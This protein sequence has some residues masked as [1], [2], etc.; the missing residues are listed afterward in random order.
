MLVVDHGDERGLRLFSI[1][2]EP[3]AGPADLEA[4]VEQP[5]AVVTDDGGRIYVLD[6]EGER[7][8]RFGPDLTYEGVIVDLAE[9]LQEP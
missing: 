9:V 3:L 1:S 2:G 8:Q 7:V 6:R 5:L 4:N